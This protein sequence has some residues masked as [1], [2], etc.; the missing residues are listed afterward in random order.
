MLN[1]ATDRSLV[2]LDE[3]GRG[4]STYDGLSLAQAILEHFVKQVKPMM[5]FATHYHE[6]TVLQDV[7]PKGIVNGHMTIA[8]QKGALRFLYQLA[9]GPAGKSYGIQVADLAG[10]PKSVVR[11][12]EGLLKSLEQGGRQN[13]ALSATSQLDLFA[14]SISAMTEEQAP[15]PSAVEEDLRGLE[16]HKMTP[17]DALNKISQ[18]QKDLF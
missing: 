10:I 8:D 12:A 14:Q 5:L 1:Q 16:I 11:H 18:W 13:G 2:I 17:L 15:E 3:V 7:Y 9:Q 4:T 6:L